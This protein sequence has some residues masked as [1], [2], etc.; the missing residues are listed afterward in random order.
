MKWVVRKTVGDTWQATKSTGLIGSHHFDEFQCLRNC[1]K[2]ASSKHILGI[3]CNSPWI[4]FA[5]IN[6]SI[7]LYLSIVS[8]VSSQKYHERLLLCKH[9]LF[10]IQRH[11]FGVHTLLHSWLNRQSVWFLCRSLLRATRY[12][13][14]TTRYGEM[15]YRHRQYHR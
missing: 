2:L 15:N 13:Y 9:R 11:V 6:N 14:V 5:F 10:E 7:V 3:L 4:F 12:L 8:M 1:D